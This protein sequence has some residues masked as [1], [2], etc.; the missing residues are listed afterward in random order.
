MQKTLVQFE[1]RK[2]V[3]VKVESS[4]IRNIWKRSLTQKEMLLGSQGAVNQ[5]TSCQHK[6]SKNNCNT[7]ER[8]G[9]KTS[10]PML[11]RVNKLWVLILLA[12]SWF[13]SY[14]PEL[15]PIFYYRDKTRVHMFYF[16]NNDSFLKKKYKQSTCQRYVSVFHS[17]FAMCL[18]CVI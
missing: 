5:T 7:L 6:L 11:Y 16:L 10:V 8:Y 9:H 3:F 12:H 2:I 17:S 15:V 14:A 13:N 1:Y 18:S 4:V